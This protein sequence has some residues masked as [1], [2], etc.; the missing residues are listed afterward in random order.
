MKKK[1]KRKTT[2]QKLY[3]TV[4]VRKQRCSEMMKNNA[5]NL[6]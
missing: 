4:T 6:Q 5:Y 1:F 2:Y 3:V